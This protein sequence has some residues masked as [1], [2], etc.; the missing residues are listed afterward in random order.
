VIEV[1]LLK[2]D[3]G[4]R[5]RGFLPD[6][7]SDA[8]PGGTKGRILEAALVAF[9]ERGFHGTSIRTIADGVGINSAT[10]YSHFASK[11]E[12]LADLVT[13][14]SRALLTRLEAELERESTAAA[15]STTADRLDAVI[16]ATVVAHATYPLLAIV[17]NSE[18]YALSGEL[19]GPALDLRSAASKLLRDI[20]ADGLADGSFTASDPLVTARVL[21]GMAQL[22]P[23]S[24]NPATDRPE[25]LAR[26]YVEIA[27]R[28]VGAA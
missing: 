4:F 22:I 13:I 6:L 2:S 5:V 20:L 23:W 16:K 15:T 10:L 24:M 3:S 27:R 1:V 9:A 8:V 7:P 19:A 21:E 17:T 14:G 28:I 12:I 26:A 18:Y 25:D 11:E